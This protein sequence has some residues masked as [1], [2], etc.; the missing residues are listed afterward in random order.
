MVWE[1]GGARR[2][3]GAAG[4]LREEGDEVGGGEDWAGG[5]ARPAWP[6]RAKRPGGLAGHWADWAKS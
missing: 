6:L 1:R 5:L 2:G 3:S 4:A